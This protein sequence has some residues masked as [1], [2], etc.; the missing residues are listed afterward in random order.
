[1][2][3]EELEVADEHERCQEDSRPGGDPGL[4]DPVLVDPVL[5]D[6]GLVDRG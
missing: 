1:M 5:V 3:R 2:G 4:V 6:P